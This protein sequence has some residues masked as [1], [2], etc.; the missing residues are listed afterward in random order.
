MSIQV[1]LRGGTSSQNNGFTGAAREVTIDTTRQTLRVHDG[2]T[3][4]GTLIFGRRSILGTV[5]QSGG[6]PTGAVIQRGS[7]SNGEFVRFADGTQIC[8]I[9]GITYQRTSD[10]VFEYIWTFPAAFDSRPVTTP[11]PN[12]FFTDWPA[13]DYRNQISM[14][15]EDRNGVADGIGGGSIRL[16]VRLLSGVSASPGDTIINCRASAVGRWF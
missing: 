8:T 11:I 16:R 9:N 15:A 1:Q 7:N 6:V 12:N 14:W 3:Q 10:T 5:S 4:G 13:G 2:I